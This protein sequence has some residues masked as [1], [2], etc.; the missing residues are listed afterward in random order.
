MVK[1]CVAGFLTNILPTK[2]QVIEWL[3]HEDNF[4]QLSA[5]RIVANKLEKG[6]LWSNIC[7][8]LSLTMVKQLNNV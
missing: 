3:L 2:K 7:C 5:A 1:F 4:L 8:L 6:W